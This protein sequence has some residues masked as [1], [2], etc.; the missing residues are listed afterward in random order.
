MCNARIEGAKGETISRSFPINFY[1]YI[2]FFLQF[3]RLKLKLKEKYIA[4]NFISVSGY[5]FLHN[6]LLGRRTLIRCRQEAQHGFSTRS[7]NR[8]K[9]Y[10]FIPN[11]YC[12]RRK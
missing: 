7:P 4:G 10:N 2:Y 3:N 5:I 1:I 6:N 8:R 9:T 12:F 11:L